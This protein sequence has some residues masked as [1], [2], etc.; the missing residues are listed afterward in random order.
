MGKRSVFLFDLLLEVNVLRL[1]LLKLI[2]DGKCVVKLLLQLLV[3]FRVSLFPFAF[4]L[5]KGIVAPSKY[6]HYA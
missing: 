1:L 4:L 2:V 6:F 5:I 3:E